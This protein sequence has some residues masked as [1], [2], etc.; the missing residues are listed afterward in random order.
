[1]NTWNSR[2]HTAKTLMD[3][4]INKATKLKYVTTIMG[5]RR[6]LPDISNKNYQNKSRAQHSIPVYSKFVQ[7]NGLKN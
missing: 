6:L 1:M 2:F 7:S 3:N 4:V 5:R